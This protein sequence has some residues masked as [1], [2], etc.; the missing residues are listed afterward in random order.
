MNLSLFLFV[1]CGLI[2]LGARSAGI[3]DAEG[4]GTRPKADLVLSDKQVLVDTFRHLVRHVLPRTNR[5]VEKLGVTP[6][7]FSVEAMDESLAAH[8]NAGIF[9]ERGAQSMTRLLKKA[10]GA[11]LTFHFYWRT[12]VAR[13]PLEAAFDLS[14]EPDGE[15]KMRLLREL[16]EA[17][18]GLSYEDGDLKVRLL[19]LGLPERVPISPRVGVVDGRKPLEEAVLELLRFKGGRLA[20]YP[21]P[22]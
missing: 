12:P 9:G 21:P 22:K 18:F 5:D 20:P 16:L 14:Y 17:A 6:G 15:L 19:W 13:E 7:N 8:A 10:R 3:S 11:S 1:G 4:K 2:L